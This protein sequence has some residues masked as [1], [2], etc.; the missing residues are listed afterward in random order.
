MVDGE[1]VSVLRSAAVSRMGGTAVDVVVDVAAIPAATSSTMAG[2]IQ[3]VLQVKTQQR[4]SASSV[5]VRMY[6]Y[7]Q[8]YIQNHRSQT[9]REQVGLQKQMTSSKAGG[10]GATVAGDNPELRSFQENLPRSSTV[11]PAA[12]LGRAG[13]LRFPLL[14]PLHPAS[15]RKQLA[16]G[17]AAQPPIEGAPSHPARASATPSPGEGDDVHP[18]ILN[19]S[20]SS[21]PPGWLLGQEIRVLKN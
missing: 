18:R 2:A 17:P 20:T 5:R 13:F 12:P 6:V 21:S 16:V 9:D 3:Y 15:P 4:P 7:V 1:V 14:L 11:H 19:F 10:N 8:G